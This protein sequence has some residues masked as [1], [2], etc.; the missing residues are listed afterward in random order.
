MSNFLTPAAFVALPFAGSIP[1][2]IINKKA[3]GWYDVSE[4]SKLIAAKCSF[5][6][7]NFSRH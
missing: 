1:G 4:I 3:M 7:E 6:D 5:A 2:G